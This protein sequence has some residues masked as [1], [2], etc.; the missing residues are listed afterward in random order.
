VS[1][2]D[3]TALELGK[4]STKTSGTSQGEDV[5]EKD[6]D[7]NAD[8]ENFDATKPDQNQSQERRQSSAEPVVSEDGT[9][10]NIDSYRFLERYF[11]K[12]HAPMIAQHKVAVLVLFAIVFVR[13]HWIV[14]YL[15]AH[16]FIST[17][18]FGVMENVGWCDVLDMVWQP[19]APPISYASDK[20]ES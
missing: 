12:Y 6:L 20:F 7:K 15:F 17:L 19:R 11:Y 4:V 5:D 1:N 2:N 18:L 13:S 10:P 14:R 9:I 3:E 16:G 8:A